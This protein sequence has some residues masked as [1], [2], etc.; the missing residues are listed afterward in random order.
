MNE[1]NDIL[2][3]RFAGNEINPHAVKPHEI[4]ELIIHFEK[5]L[6]S[7]IKDR[8]PEIDTNELLFAFDEIRNE[9]IGVRFIPKLVRD[10]VVSSFTFISTSFET[11]DFSNVSNK[12][13]AE[14]K[15]FTK[16]S[17]KYNCIGEFKLNGQ[18][19]S[20]F[21]PTTELEYNKNP[22]LEGEVKIFG[23]VMDSGGDNP[24]VHLKINDDQK[25]IFSTSEINAKELAHKLYEK[26]SIVGIAKWDAITYE[27]IS[28]KIKEIIDFTPGKTLSAINELRNLTSGVWDRYNTNDEINN[29]LLRD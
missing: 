8:H 23:R 14:L 6:L 4:A 27:I 19:L 11:G 21:T 16:F 13:I 1:G 9:S 28:F 5:A 29:Q 15:T 24:N 25:L 22:I 12:T 7:D 3:V 2:E 26:V 10:V 17:K 18:N 20:T